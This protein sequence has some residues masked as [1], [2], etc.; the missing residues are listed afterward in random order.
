MTV[1]G[2]LIEFANMHTIYMYIYTELSDEMDILKSFDILT[3]ALMPIY[4]KNDTNGCN[5]II[6]SR[7]NIY[8]GL[9]TPATLSLDKIH[10]T[11]YNINT[12]A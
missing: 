3:A 12:M 10:Q 1:S 5:F 8:S 6:M 2:D 7:V 4:I 11:D 9:F